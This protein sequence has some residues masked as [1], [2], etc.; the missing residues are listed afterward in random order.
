MQRKGFNNNRQ[1]RGRTFN[2]RIM[3]TL[4]TCKEESFDFNLKNRTVDLG[5]SFKLKSHQLQ[6]HTVYK[7]VSVNKVKMKNRLKQALR[8][9]PN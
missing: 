3:A 2:N 1:F 6:D 7:Q 4:P 9:L 8:G 5:A